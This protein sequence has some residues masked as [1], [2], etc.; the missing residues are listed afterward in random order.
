MLAVVC[1][2]RPMPL[3]PWLG[4]MESVG[5][6][7]FGVPTGFPVPSLAAVAGRRLLRPRRPAVTTAGYI[8]GCGGSGGRPTRP[9]QRRTDAA[10]SVPAAAAWQ[11]LDSATVRN[12]HPRRGPDAAVWDSP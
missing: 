8:G 11:R 5:R 2:E 6:C 10:S 4:T 7:A 9:R 12:R 3:R 1:G